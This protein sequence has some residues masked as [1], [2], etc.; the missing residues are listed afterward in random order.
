[1][2][3]K[4]QHK[5]RGVG[6]GHAIWQECIG[7]WE[8]RGRWELRERLRDRW[9]PGTRRQVPERIYVFKY[10]EPLFFWSPQGQ[11]WNL[12]FQLPLWSQSLQTPV[13]K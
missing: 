8:G 12:D 2:L 5:I 11:E 13:K 1:M 7:T 3:W 4:G 10:K 6:K 9:D